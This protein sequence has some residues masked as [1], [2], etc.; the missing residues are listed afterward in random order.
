MLGQQPGVGIRTRGEGLRETLMQVPPLTRQQMGV[1]HLPGQR[2]AEG[3]AI[4]GR[5]QQAR[6][7]GPARRG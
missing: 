3:I 2:M 6:G 4:A 1:E 5:D 7:D